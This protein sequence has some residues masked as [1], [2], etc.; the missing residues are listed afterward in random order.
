MFALCLGVGPAGKSSEQWKDTASSVGQKVRWLLV[1]ICVVQLC[2]L[3]IL[4][5]SE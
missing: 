5:V 2:M 4:N 1:S 3:F